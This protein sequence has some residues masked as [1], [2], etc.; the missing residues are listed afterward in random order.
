MQGFAAEDL[1]VE[2]DQILL[3]YLQEGFETDLPITLTQLRKCLARGG[4]PSVAATSEEGYTPLHFFAMVGSQNPSEASACV[5]ALLDFGADIKSKDADGDTALDAVLSVAEEES[6]DEREEEA[7]GEGSKD[8]P[9]AQEERK[10]ADEVRSAV[11]RALLT[12]PAGADLLQEDSRLRKLCSWARRHAKGRVGQELVAQLRLLVGDQAVSQLWASE[13]LLD[14]LG[15]CCYVDECDVDIKLVKK[16]LDAGAKPSHRL[17]GKATA[18][19][20]I[21]LNPHLKYK[22]ANAV[23]RLLMEAEPEVVEVQDG[24]GMTPLNWAE[25]YISIA[26]QHKQKKPN[27]AALIAISEHVSAPTDGGL[28]GIKVS[29]MRPEGFIPKSDPLAANAAPGRPA[30]RFM[31]GDRVEV[32]VA[33][34]GNR[35]F[36][37]EEGVV[38]TLRSIEAWWPHSHPGVPY[39]VL[40]DIGTRILV[41][42]DRDAVIRCEGSGRE[43]K[44]K[45]AGWNSNPGA[46][47]KAKAKPRFEKRRRDDGQWE[48]VDTTTGKVRPIAPPDSDDD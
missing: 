23:V 24:F 48:L 43:M 12:Y 1:P 39:E 37:W 8:D 21:A 44:S 35:G 5:Q 42:V 18:L 6:D 7:K 25:D 26:K 29:Q 4:P 45:P 41:I 33:D 13:E 16:L 31:E 2:Q 47:A 38:V 3:R 19:H 14:H 9:E 32:K 10:H 28:A 36:T 15:D 17:N 46:K 11:I 30:L 22:V 27:P 34:P 40:L 20:L